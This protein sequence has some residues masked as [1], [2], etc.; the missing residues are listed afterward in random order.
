MLSNCW[1][2]H[3][4]RYYFKACHSCSSLLQSKHCAALVVKIS[5][6]ASA[7]TGLAVYFKHCL[8]C[9]YVYTCVTSR[10]TQHN[11]P[12]QLA[13]GRA[14]LE[15]FSICMYVQ[16]L[17]TLHFGGQSYGIRA[18]A[19]CTDTY[20]NNVS[21]CSFLDNLCL[22]GIHLTPITVVFKSHYILS[23]PSLLLYCLTF[24]T[25]S[26]VFAAKYVH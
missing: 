22:Y 6:Y 11:N 25:C 21:S 16:L 20:C 1:V 2:S 14:L 3:T 8:T 12:F 7:H 23:S 13:I 24:T 9:V 15:T 19:I 5:V 26:C 10:P 18:V 4:V 17:C